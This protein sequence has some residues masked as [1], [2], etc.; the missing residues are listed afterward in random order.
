M[1]EEKLCIFRNACTRKIKHK[2][3]TGSIKK[4]EH[5]LHDIILQQEI[6]TTHNCNAKL[7]T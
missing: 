4:K 1:N 5:Q 7:V 2:F 6:Q 3:S